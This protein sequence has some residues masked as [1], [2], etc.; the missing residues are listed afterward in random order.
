M[1][2]PNDDVLKLVRPPT[3]I[4]Q[5]AAETLR[6]AIVTGALAPGERLVESSLAKRMGVSRPSIREALSQL[7]AEKIVTMTPNRG[8]T[9]AT[10]TWPEAESIYEVRALLEADAAARC[11]TLATDDDVAHMRKSLHDFEQ[12]LPAYDVSILVASTAEFYAVLLRACGN[13]VIAEIIGGL[14]A[15]ISFLR[16]KSMSRRGRAHQSLVELTAILAAIEARNAH[17]ARRACAIHVQNAMMAAGA[18]FMEMKP[19]RAD[20]K[21]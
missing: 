10:I 4:R 3:L 19:S 2:S 13:P 15:R 20:E 9:V 17:D 16:A 7:A 18:A 21:A 8:P 5:L 1:D 6:S 11:A 12:A 14:T